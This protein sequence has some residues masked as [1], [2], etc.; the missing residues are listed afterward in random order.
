MNKNLS[1]LL[2]GIKPLLLKAETLK[3]KDSHEK[4]ETH[5]NL[6]LI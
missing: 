1:Y 6:L 4:K 2:I 5:S 3:R